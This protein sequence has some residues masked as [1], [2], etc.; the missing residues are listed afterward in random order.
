MMRGENW[1]TRRKT[2]ELLY[3][4]IACNL[5]TYICA[6]AKM[7]GM[8]HDQYASL[9][10]HDNPRTRDFQLGV[11]KM[12]NHGITLAMITESRLRDEILIKLN[13]FS[14]PIFQTVLICSGY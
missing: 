12:N 7:G 5:V 13:A 14:S 1:S 8:F 2:L 9:A 6:I 3:V 10:P 4:D 11:K